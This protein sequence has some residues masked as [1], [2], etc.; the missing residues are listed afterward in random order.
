MSWVLT[1]YQ[2]HAVQM[3][4]CPHQWVTLVDTAGQGEATEMR[5]SSATVT[6]S[7]PRTF[8]MLSP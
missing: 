4:V 1:P 6:V 3:G 8:L 7:Q 5:D 2:K